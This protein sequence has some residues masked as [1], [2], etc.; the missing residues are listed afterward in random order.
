MP[1]AQKQRVVKFDPEALAYKEWVQDLVW[2]ELRPK[3]IDHA[4]AAGRDVVTVE[5]MKACLEDALSQAMPQ[6][7]DADAAP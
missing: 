5:D 1:V 2:R 6:L 3:V 4:F 7:V